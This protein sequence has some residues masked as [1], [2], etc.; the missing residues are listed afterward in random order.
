MGYWRHLS[1]YLEVQVTE[2]ARFVRTGRRIFFLVLALGLSVLPLG[3]NAAKTKASSEAGV[4][5]KFGFTP[6]PYD[7]TAEA[8]AKTQEIIDQA[9]NLYALHFDDCIPWNELIKDEPFPAYFQDDWR[10]LAGNTPPGHAVYVGV[11]LLAKDRRNPAPTCGR[12]KG[13]MEDLPKKLRGPLDSDEMKKAYLRYIQRAVDTFH[14]QFL[15]I[16]IESDG[17]AAHVPA[18]WKQFENLFGYVRQEIKKQHP[19]IQIGVSLGLQTLLD[20]SVAERAKPLVE[21]S[22]YFGLSFYPYAS[23]MGEKFGAPAL[24][25][26]DRRWRGPLEWARNYTNKPVAIC[27]TGFT[28]QNIN[29]RKYDLRMQG[30]VDSQAAYVK[31]L[32]NTAK[33]QRYMFVVWFL[34]VD[35]DQ[36]YA[37][38]PDNSEK[39][40]NLLWRNIGMYDGHLKQKRAWKE[41]MEWKTPGSGSVPAPMA[42]APVAAPV[43]SAPSAARAGT[44]IGFTG[45]GD[46]FGCAPGGDVA[47]SS[48]GGPK[49]GVA[50]MR[51]SFTY[52][53]DWQWCAK[54]LAGKSLA[55]AQSLD[56]WVRSDRQG[57]LFL[58]LEE[59]GGESFYSLLQVD[60]EWQRV[61]LPLS[62]FTVDPA[63][64]KDGRL[65]PDQIAKLVIADPS[66]QDGASGQRT[67]QFADLAFR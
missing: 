60:T 45:K 66:G 9:S 22:D 52:K 4:E 3:G 11:A 40:V 26:G 18:R 43:A 46:L 59:R 17:L 30:D 39:E 5:T 19:D 13:R 29:I 16:G 57:P 1:P 62:A 27:E 6:F 36:L 24:G 48:D 42:A 28:T 31:Y 7:A 35:Y 53:R 63:K 37:K 47:L 65:D 50:N 61:T 8:V 38:M 2:A 41:W 15:N 32:V 54:E 67:I 21:N 55:N 64:K 10:R 34:A 56:V 20:P 51:W 44:V 23:A 12:N 33:Q 25:D 49:A 14:P 58:T